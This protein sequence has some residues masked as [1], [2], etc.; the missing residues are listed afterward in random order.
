MGDQCP[1]AARI[2]NQDVL[3]RWIMQAVPHSLVASPNGSGINRPDT[4]DILAPHSSCRNL[5]QRHRLA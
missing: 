2:V 5:C 4:E 1:Q 3:A